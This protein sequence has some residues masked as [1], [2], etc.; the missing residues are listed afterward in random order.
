MKQGMFVFADTRKTRLWMMLAGFGFCIAGYLRWPP[1]FQDRAQVFL[2]D[3]VMGF[4]PH[5]YC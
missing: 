4:I 5:V 1:E 2:W 3:F